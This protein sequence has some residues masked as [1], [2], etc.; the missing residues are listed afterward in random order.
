[1]KETQQLIYH[2]PFRDRLAGFGLLPKTNQNVQKRIY[3]V[4]NRKHF[5]QPGIHFHKFTSNKIGKETHLANVSDNEYDLGEEGSGNREVEFI[6]NRTSAK[7]EVTR[8]S[9]DLAD[10]LQFSYHE[11]LVDFAIYFAHRNL[12]QSHNHE[13]EFIATG[14][15]SQISKQLQEFVSTIRKTYKCL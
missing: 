6:I 4:D 12:G 11:R 1:M 8:V 15:P 7:I 9:Q 2:T 14:S 3:L 13:K 5:D 10:Q